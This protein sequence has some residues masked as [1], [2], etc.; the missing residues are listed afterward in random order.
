M[1]LNI[2]LLDGSRRLIANAGDMNACINSH[3]LDNSFQFVLRLSP[4]VHR[5]IAALPKGIVGGPLDFDGVQGS[6][7]I[8]MKRFTR[9]AMLV[10]SLACC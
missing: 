9:G 3:G 2:D 4:E 10:R 8:C 7:P 5:R 6:R 1:Q